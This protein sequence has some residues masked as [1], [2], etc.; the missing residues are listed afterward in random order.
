MLDAGGRHTLE[1]P[2]TR[3][4]PPPKPPISTRPRPKKGWLAARTRPYSTVYLGRRKLGVT[5]FADVALP[6][7]THL[8]TFKNP[9][10]KTQRRRITIR[11]GKTRKLDFALP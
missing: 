5:P 2:L 8:L 4:P 10:H 7:G 6:A 3:A 11:P 1:Y 9:N